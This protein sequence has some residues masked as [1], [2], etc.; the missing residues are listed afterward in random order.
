VRI[1]ANRCEST[2]QK[3]TRA[4]VFYGHK[5]PEDH[6]YVLEFFKQIFKKKLL[7]SACR[8]TVLVTKLVPLPL[9]QYDL[10]CPEVGPYLSFITF[11]NTGEVRNDLRGNR[12]VPLVVPVQDFTR[13]DWSQLRQSLVSFFH[14]RRIKVSLFL[15]VRVHRN[16]TRS[17]SHIHANFRKNPVGENVEKPFLVRIRNCGPKS[18]SHSLFVKEADQR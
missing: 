13:G 5:F 2:Q 16:C 7:I 3:P 12:L 17:M 9:N 8:V 4:C 14:D 18:L 6:D 11:F 10:V 15:Q 1:G